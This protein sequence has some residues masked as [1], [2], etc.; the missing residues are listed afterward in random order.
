M[1]NIYNLIAPLKENYIE[2]RSKP[3]L[4]VPTIDSQLS[5]SL[6]RIQQ[7]KRVLCDRGFGHRKWIRRSHVV[8]E[9]I[10]NFRSLLKS[11]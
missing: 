10:F 6:H 5:S 2:A 7:K 4:W 11:S 1:S 8:L 3:S 9:S